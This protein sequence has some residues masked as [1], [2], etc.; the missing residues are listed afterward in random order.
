[1]AETPP[2]VASV[3][4][5]VVR[6]GGVK[7][8]A[9]DL[10]TVLQVG[11]DATWSDVPCFRFANAY[12][13]ALAQHDSAYFELLNGP[14]VNFA[15][16]HPVARA[17]RAAVPTAGQVRG[18]SLF[19][20]ALRV[21]I[22]PE[23]RHY[24]LGSSSDVLQRIKSRAEGDCAGIRIVGT[25]SP[26]FRP[27]TDADIDEMVADIRRTGATVVWVG[28]GTPKQDFV[29]LRLAELLRVPCLA[30]GAAFDFY[31]GTKRAAPEW[32]RKG[33]LEWVFRLATEP[34]RLWKRY[35]W[36]NTIFLLSL[37]RRG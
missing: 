21:W 6:V 37:R 14:G 7:F 33:G 3:D 30:V 4:V 13:V 10:E 22:G 11:P 8:A 32:M 23:H 24:L 31:A 35:L 34:R 12:S 27:M 26:P 29:A 28:L 17:L 18:P 25:M 16:G 9:T 1:M 2:V 19:E 5:P 20:A 36:G 15:D